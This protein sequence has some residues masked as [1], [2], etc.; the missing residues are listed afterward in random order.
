MELGLPI[1]LRFPNQKYTRHS[2]SYVTV[3][4]KDHVK[5]RIGEFLETNVY[6]IR[7]LR[8]VNHFSG[9]LTPQ[10]RLRRTQDELMLPCL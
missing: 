9:R 8:T 5:N 4:T 6:T 3:G 1:N 2:T 10:T 7:I